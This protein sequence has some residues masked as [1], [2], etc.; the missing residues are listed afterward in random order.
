MEDHLVPLLYDELRRLAAGYLARRPKGQTLQAT[1]LVHEAWMR[2]AERGGATG[3]DR[4]H[5]LA[6]AATVMRQL[7]VD[8]AR[9]NG[10]L[11]RGGGWARV[12]LGDALEGEPGSDEVD[13][14]ALDEALTRLAKLNPER[15][16]LV[17]LRAFGGSTLEEAAEALGISRSEAA[18]RW[19]IV[20]AWLASQLH[21]GADS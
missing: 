13:L 15:A 19:R 10:A 3:A 21:G 12:T 18:R 20:K 6:L 11:K 4:G 17:E 9:E 7:L 8:H 14:L 16:R 1:A 5:F 2:L